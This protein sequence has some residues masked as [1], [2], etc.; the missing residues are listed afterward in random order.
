MGVKDSV[1]FDKWIDMSWQVSL[2]PFAFSCNVLEL[3]VSY[4]HVC[5]GCFVCLQSQ[6]C[7]PSVYCSSW[8]CGYLEE[9]QLVW[10]EVL[11]SKNVFPFQ[12]N[13]LS[14]SPSLKLT[15]SS[16][17]QF[18]FLSDLL[19]S[20]FIPNPSCKPFLSQTHQCFLWTYNIYNLKKQFAFQASR[21]VQES[22]QFIKLLI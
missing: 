13:F 14:P 10:N 17:F 12:K 19:S 5:K 16:Q 21:T 20:L 7:Q 2:T 11:V 9:E 18:L 6:S 3:C 4:C 15:I 8:C 22:T 1:P